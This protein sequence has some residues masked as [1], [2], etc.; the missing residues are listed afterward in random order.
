MS[1]RAKILFCKGFHLRLVLKSKTLIAQLF[2]QINFNTN[3]CM[4]LN[5]V[6]LCTLNH[7]LTNI[8]WAIYSN[9]VCK[10]SSSLQRLLHASLQP[11]LTISAQSLQLQCFNRGRVYVRHLLRINGCKMP[12]WCFEIGAKKDFFEN[13]LNMDWLLNIISTIDTV[14]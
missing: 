7:L 11:Y 2:P 3:N 9:A 12:L 4:T 8:Q 14:E 10:C 13:N 6:P 5:G 1:K